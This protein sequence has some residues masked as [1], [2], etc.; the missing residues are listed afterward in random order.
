MLAVGRVLH[1]LPEGKDVW[2]VTSLDNLIYVLRC[3]SLQ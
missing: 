2:G 3:K 1:V